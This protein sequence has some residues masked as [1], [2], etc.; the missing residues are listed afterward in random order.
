VLGSHSP[1]PISRILRR[2]FLRSFR[3]QTRDFHDLFI[4][5]NGMELSRP[6]D[7]ALGGGDAGVMV[8]DAAQLMHQL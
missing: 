1:E 8:L 3:E 6:L 7:D 5:A 4:Q 2:R